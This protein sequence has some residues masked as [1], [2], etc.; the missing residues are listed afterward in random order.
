MSLTPLPQPLA[1][2]PNFI[3]KTERT[4]LIKEKVLSLSGDSFDIKTRDGETMFKV[5][6]KTFTIS[7]RKTLLDV[8]GR[9]LLTIRKK[10]L[11]LH[12]SYYADD[13]SGNRVFDLQGK[14][15]SA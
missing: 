1:V 14:F 6:G 10:H 7:G 15:S 11:S 8:Q 5:Q 13:P 12:G 2:F 9:P 3:A 4:F